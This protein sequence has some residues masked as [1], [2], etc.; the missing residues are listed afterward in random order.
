MGYSFSPSLFLGALI[1]YDR[2]TDLVNAN[3]R[4]NFI[5]SP[6]SN[7]YIV[8]NEQRFTFDGAPAPG[9]SVILKITK[10]LAM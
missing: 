2:D 6:L 4:F 3:V 5:H 1:Q 7:V 8:Y 10:M 9:R